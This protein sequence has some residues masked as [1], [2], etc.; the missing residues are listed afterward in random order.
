[1]WRPLLLVLACVLAG[2]GGPAATAPTTQTETLTPVPVPAESTPPG[3]ESK[4]LVDG[5][6][7]AA[8]HERAVANRS[9]T[10]R[11]R[12]RVVDE[13]GTLRRLNTTR[14]VVAGGETYRGLQVGESSDRYPVS[15]AATKVDVFYT[16]GTSLI[17]IEDERV[18]YGR[19]DTP[20]GVLEDLSAADRLRELY[21]AGDNWTVT[22]ADGRYVLESRSVATG[23]LRQP[24]LVESLRGVRLRVVVTETGRLV[25][26][27]L[28]YEGEFEGQKVRVRRTTTL[29]AVG[30]TS[31]P[32]P[33]WLGTARNATG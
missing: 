23:A 13:N 12:F 24:L 29:T 17:R 21:L 20:G 2:C 25:G 1:M 9:Y 4:R 10:V 16:N 30:N 7:L 19:A 14:W 27:R 26:W 33:S 32:R 31:V 28:T 15:S 18:R 5:D 6:A 22:P 11:S 8:A 3:I